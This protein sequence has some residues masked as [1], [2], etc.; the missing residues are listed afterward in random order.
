MLIK[1]NTNFGCKVLCLIYIRS[2]YRLLSSNIL[3]ISSKKKRPPSVSDETDAR[4]AKRRAPRPR[5]GLTAVIAILVRLRFKHALH[6]E[7]NGISPRPSVIVLAKIGPVRKTR[8]RPLRVYAVPALAAVGPVTG[9]CLTF[10]ILCV[11]RCAT[12]TYRP[13][14]DRCPNGPLAPLLL[15]VVSRRT[16]ALAP[17]E[18]V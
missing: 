6:K 7:S 8:R 15:T 14:I 13:L 3:V 18:K 16:G 9:R 10:W 1:F 2:R 17:K 11:A 4:P 5:V 12:A